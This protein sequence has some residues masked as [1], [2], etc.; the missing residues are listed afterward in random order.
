MDL[1]NV[2]KGLLGS[3]MAKSAGDDLTLRPYYDRAVMDGEID[4]S[5]LPYE[6]WKK[7]QQPSAPKPEML[8]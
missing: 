5:I 7:L 2:L 8:Q 1:S 3:G 4:P 6:A